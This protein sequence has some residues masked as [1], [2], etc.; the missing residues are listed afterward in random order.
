MLKAQNISYY[1]RNSEGFSLRDVSF[2]F[3]AGIS[4]VCWARTARARPR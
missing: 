1:Y 4:W 2:P 3:R